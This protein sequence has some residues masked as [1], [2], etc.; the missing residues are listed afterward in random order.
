MPETLL[1]QSNAYG[2]D[3]AFTGPINIAWVTVLPYAIATETV[4]WFNCNSASAIVR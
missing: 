2:V 1:H 3:R 4:I